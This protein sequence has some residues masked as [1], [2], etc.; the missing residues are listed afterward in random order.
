M[1]EILIFLVEKHK[2][3]VTE[4][5][6]NIIQKLLN[7]GFDK[8]KIIKAIKNMKIKEKK[9]DIKLFDNPLTFEKYLNMFEPDLPEWTKDM[10]EHERDDLKRSYKIIVDHCYCATSS[11]TIYN[12]EILQAIY[13]LHLKGLSYWVIEAYFKD[14]D[15]FGYYPKKDYDILNEFKD[16]NLLIQ[17]CCEIFRKNLEY[18]KNPKEIGKTL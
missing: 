2:Y 1:N 15:K 18:Q 10:T 14:H 8:W 12:L 11:R 4:E 13:K 17:K 6:R 5:I 16:E 9:I 7:I 3:K